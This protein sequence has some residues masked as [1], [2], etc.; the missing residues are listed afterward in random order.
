M[1][2]SGKAGAWQEIS[3]ALRARFPATMAP[4]RLQDALSRTQRLR[5]GSVPGSESP[6]HEEG[7][8]KQGSFTVLGGGDPQLLRTRLW[9]FKYVSGLGR[10]A[11]PW[12]SAPL[13]STH[14]RPCPNT[15]QLGLQRREDSGIG[16]GW[17]LEL[18]F[19]HG[20]AVREG[21]FEESELGRKEGIGDIALLRLCFVWEL[22][23]R[24]NRG[25]KC[26]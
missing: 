8:C 3:V 1:W 22:S 9:P 6:I 19:L 17:R 2:V 21:A 13:G 23:P 16:G 5:G 4:S 26:Q 24:G 11:S 15:G 14:L 25:L 7:V 12:P 10:G 20:G 18:G